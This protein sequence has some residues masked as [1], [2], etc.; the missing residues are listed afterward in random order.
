MLQLIDTLYHGTAQLLMK[1][2]LIF[3]IAWID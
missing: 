2:S 3:R 1:N